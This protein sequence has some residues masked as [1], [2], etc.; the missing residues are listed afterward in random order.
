MRAMVNL[1]PTMPAEQL[2]RRL[3]FIRDLRD[4]GLISARAAIELLRLL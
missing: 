1:L 4:A 3:A 2:L